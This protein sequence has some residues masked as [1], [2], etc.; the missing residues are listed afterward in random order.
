MVEEAGKAL[1]RDRILVTGATGFIGRHTVPALLREYD[2]LRLCLRSAASCPPHWREDARIELCR[3]DDLAADDLDAAVAGV[4]AVVHLAGLATG[5]D[6]AEGLFTRANVTTTERL[7]AAA[8]QAGVSTFI[9]LSSIMAVTPNAAMAIVDDAT[10]PQPA[11]AYGRSKRLAEQALRRIARP[12]S[13]AISL[14]PPLV[15]GADAKGNWARLQAVAASGLPL[16]F[17]SIDSPRSLVAVDFLAHVISRLCHGGLPAELSGEYCVAATLPATL[18][19]MIRELRAGMSLRPR[20]FR[21]PPAMLLVLGRLS[22]LH[23]QVASLTAP[24]RVDA[25]RL[26]AAFGIAD[27]APIGEAIRRSGAGYRALREGRGAEPTTP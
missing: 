11:N 14:R 15:I 19:G 8:R 5:P 18:P 16:P 9:H 20:L 17:A 2:G 13:L 26:F 4:G 27:D 24:L 23:Q 10:P 25:S 3:I 6:A 22:G 1:Q 7:A 12:D 21:C